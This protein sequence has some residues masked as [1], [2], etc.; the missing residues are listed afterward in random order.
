MAMTE[1]QVQLVIA[2]QSGD[3]KSFEELFAIY[4]EKVYAL[5]RMITKNAGDAE[6]ILQE[7]F[8][9]A[10]RKLN[11]LKTPLSFSVWIQIIAK[12]LCNM[13]L[14]KKNMAIML[15]AEQDIENIYMEESEE[16]LP[17][18][19]TE[20]ADLKERLGRIIDGLSEVQ[21]QSIVLY[22]YND[23]SVEE[24]SGVMECSAN[25]VKTRL[26]L[27]RKA[28]RSEIEEQERKSGEKFY[29]IAGV[30]L[31]SLGKLIRAH[32]QS[33]SIGQRSAIDSFNVITNSI[34]NTSSM[35]AAGRAAEPVKLD[36]RKIVNKMSLKA[37]I[38]AGISAVA[39]VGA[40][41]VLAILA[42]VGFGKNDP[43]SSGAHAPDI[44]PS[45]AVSASETSGTPP[46]PD[47]AVEETP[48]IAPPTTPSPVPPSTPTP[49]S[50]PT[51]SYAYI[52]K[53][54]ERMDIYQNYAFDYVDWL[55]GTEAVEQYKQDHPR[56][57]QTE[58]EEAVEEYG[59][60]RNANQQ[61]KWLYP[62]DSTEYYMPDARISA[63]PVR[64]GYQ[65][66]KDR[67]IPAIENGETWLAFVKVTVSGET[68][69]KIEWVYH[70]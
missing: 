29:G 50:E 30:P 16:Y 34:L 35:N 8:I 48:S 10:W 39:T 3:T 9:T 13:Q 17:V 18:I 21:R 42:R 33:L 15:D 38:I 46:E 54:S 59:Y 14:R 24:I 27:A 5:A 51:W 68:I 31:M 69:V 23:L 66:F 43:A 65:T 37:K 28:I 55:T 11:T 20:R 67:M 2:A 40:V 25:T 61:L 45:A 6:D 62:T 52:T 41:A 49:S 57:S 63:T 7:T 4:Y 47:S 64:V 12:N 36:E 26:F 1:Q 70:P 32:I 60:I 44:S 19:Y 58:A 22:Y 56:I 53:W